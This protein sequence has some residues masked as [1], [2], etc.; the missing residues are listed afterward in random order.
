MSWGEHPGTFNRRAKIMIEKELKDIILQVVKEKNGLNSI[1]LILD[2]MRLS[3]IQKFSQVEYNRNIEQLIKGG[4][5]I[6][7]E[8]IG[9]HINYRIKSLY[10]IKGTTFPNIRSMNAPD[11]KSVV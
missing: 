6:E 9:P 2:V 8:Y 7:L 4:D 11:R 5:I 3:N 10:F 1:T